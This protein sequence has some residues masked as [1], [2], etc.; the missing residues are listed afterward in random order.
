MFH[1]ELRLETAY[2]V[3]VQ[4][5]DFRLKSEFDI[6]CLL[7]LCR[8][9]DKSFNEVSYLKLVKGLFT[10]AMAARARTLKDFDL[11]VPGFRHSPKPPEE[12]TV[13]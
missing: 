7:R 1:L 10:Q 11:S 13:P 12:Q 6:S 8:Y 3:P 4:S 5:C 2:L 9:F